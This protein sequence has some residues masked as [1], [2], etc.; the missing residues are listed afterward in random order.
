VTEE[1]RAQRTGRAGTFRI[2]VWHLEHISVAIYTRAA[3]K[4]MSHVVILAHNIRGGCWWYSSR[5]WTFPHH[6]AVPFCCRVTVGSRGLVWQN[7]VWCGS[8]YEVKVWKW[9]PI[10][11]KNGP[12]WHS[13]TLGEHLWR[14]N[15]GCEHSEA[16]GSVFQQWQQQYEKQAKFQTT[17]QI[18]TS[19]VWRLFFITGENT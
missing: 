14:P 15:S 5:G 3:L 16:V 13:S 12:H 10:C 8:V 17:L 4:V 9:G 18:F 2:L 19:V 6:Y 1:H 11:G 7:G